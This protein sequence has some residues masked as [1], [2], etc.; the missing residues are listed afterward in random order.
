M[1]PLATA[2]GGTCVSHQA[3]ADR[4]S[5]LSCSETQAQTRQTIFDRVWR[6]FV[7]DHHGTGVNAT[8]RNCKYVA[9]DGGYCA[10]GLVLPDELRR[11]LAGTR[12]N[13]LSFSDLVSR[14]PELFAMLGKAST[15]FWR[16]LQRVR[17][18]AVLQTRPSGTEMDNPGFLAAI[19]YNL[20]LFADRYGLRV[21]TN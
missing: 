20:R 6:W 11:N 2:I 5:N 12:E 1:G 14:R 8:D 10:I 17:D 4:R 15:G 7:I 9:E 21:P 3:A 16:D 18:S 13:G 19:E